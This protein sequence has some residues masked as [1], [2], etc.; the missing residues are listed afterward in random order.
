MITRD[1][2]VIWIHDKAIILKDEYGNPIHLQG[3]MFDI[4]ERK[5]AEEAL[6]EYSERL[7]EMVKERTK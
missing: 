6:K 5:R 2:R 3:V 4:T 1:G 7:E